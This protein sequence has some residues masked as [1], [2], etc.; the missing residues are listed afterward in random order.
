MVWHM[1]LLF[2]TISCAAAQYAWL[3]PVVLMVIGLAMYR[4]RRTYRSIRLLAGTWMKQLFKHVSLLRQVSKISLLSI[5]VL[6]LILALMRPQWDQK[7]EV[8]AQQGRDLFIAL[9]ISRSMLAGDVKPD[10]LTYAKNK[11]KQLLK[12][13]NAERVGLILFS[14]SAFVQCPLTADYAAFNLYLNQVGVETISAGSTALAQVLKEVLRV[15]G[16]MADRKNKLLV[17]LTDG[18]D[19]SSD[20]A[21][22]KQ[23]AQQAGLH[24]FALGI[25]TADGAP[26]PLYDERGNRVGHQKDDKGT[27]VISHLNEPLLN[28]LASEVGGTYIRSTADDADIMSVIGHVQKFE[29]EKFDDKTVSSLEDKYHY[30]LLISFICFALEWLI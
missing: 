4:T 20:L 14:G 2:F 23:E 5:G 25:G 10:R 30:C 26:I 16:R 12:H 15:F 13:L 1:K 8:V 24:I 22:V 6:F 21:A 28:A 9:D 29:K 3:L 17:L 19:F 18:E 7:E 27:I 11:I